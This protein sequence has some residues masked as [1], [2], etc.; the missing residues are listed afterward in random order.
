[1]T[2]SKLRDLGACNALENIQFYHGP[3]KSKQGRP[4]ARREG[5][6]K[7]DNTD[8]VEERTPLASEATV[9]GQTGPEYFPT[10][11]PP[12]ME[13]LAHDSISADDCVIGNE[14]SML[15]HIPSM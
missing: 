1:M 4:R 15:L 6:G 13:N 7:R 11:S 9:S 14:H 10:D 3:K 12:E 2:Y 5:Q 8:K